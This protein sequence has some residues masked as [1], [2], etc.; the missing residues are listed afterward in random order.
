MLND[1]ELTRTLRRSLPPVE[2]AVPSRDLWPAVRNHTPERPRWSLVDYGI[3][4]LIA[5]AL[6]L[7]PNW[8]WFLAYHL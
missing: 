5:V 2:S 8:F 3:V 4:A 1:E 6:V 7:F